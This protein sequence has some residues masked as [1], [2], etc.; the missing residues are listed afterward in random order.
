M[1]RC[2]VCN[3][4]FT[5]LISSASCP[6]CGICAGVIDGFCAY[7]PFLAQDGGGFQSNY[8]ATLA[9]LEAKN[10]W[11]R[12]RNQLI[13]WALKNY[14]HHFSSFLEIG[15][16]TG[17]VLSGVA[18]AFPEATLN[19][20]EIFTEGLK[21]AFKRV[22]E[23][24]FMQMDARNIPF[25]DEFDVIG[26]FDVLEHIQEDELVLSQAYAALKSDGHII[27]TVP[28]HKWLW[29][30]VDEYSYHVRRY[31]AT[32]L[33]QKLQAAGFEMIRSTSFVTTLLPAMMLSRLV[34][35]KKKIDMNSMSS[36]LKITP[37]I[38]ELFF[39]LLEIELKLIKMGVNFPVGG[40]RL[41]I[42][43]KMNVR[44]STT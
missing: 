12:A 15:C 33:H 8:F 19:G 34:K 36:E 44:V 39:R 42:A 40:S 5:S 13:Q 10:F 14:C 22:P 9:P 1:N 6:A 11:F 37:W 18:K 41:V 4:F 16:G 27:I 23:A 43:K 25:I 35:Q 26:A 24:N 7:A 21:F 29:S 30:T 17:Y 31:T 3:A 2:L 32:E 20:S 28:Q 38:N